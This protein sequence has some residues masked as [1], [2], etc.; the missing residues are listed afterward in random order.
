M[1]RIQ[2]PYVFS[3]VIIGLISRLIP[4]PPNCTA[5]HAIALLAPCMTGGLFAAV[6][7]VYLTMI[8]SDWLI[9]SHASLFFVYSSYAVSIC[10]GRWLARRP[11]FSRYALASLL[12]VGIFYLLTNFG[13]WL[14]SPLYAKS[15]AGLLSSYVAAL[16]FVGRELL[17]ALLYGA[18]IFTTDS[19]VCRGRAKGWGSKVRQK[20]LAEKRQQSGG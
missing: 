20:L 10:I 9:G 12:S 8:C 16:P 15:T 2:L 11:G 1:L 13:E 14:I 18:L 19:L 6:L 4:H 3:L 5:M 7:C 17:F